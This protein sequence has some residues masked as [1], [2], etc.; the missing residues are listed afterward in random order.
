[1]G[2]SS[3]APKIYEAS[4]MAAM[5]KDKVEDI[6]SEYVSLCPCRPCRPCVVRILY[7]RMCV[8]V[9]PCVSHH[10]SLSCLH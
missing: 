1:M 10:L 2:C 7:C 4:I 6:H 3:S 9:S 5:T 8:Y